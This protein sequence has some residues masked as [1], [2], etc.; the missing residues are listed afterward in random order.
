ML[1]S[2]FVFI[3]WFELKYM[4]MSRRN[5]ALVSELS[6]PPPEA[7]DLY[8][9][10]QFSQSTWGQLKSCIWKQWLTYWRSPDYNLVRYFFTLVAALMVGTVFWRVGKKRFGAASYDEIKPNPIFLTI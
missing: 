8:F 7:K 4:L 3:C 2:E 10:T 1:L 5:K 9:P 6:T